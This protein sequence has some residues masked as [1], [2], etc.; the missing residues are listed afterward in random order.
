MAKFCGNC[1]A[2]MDD[3]AAV[4]GY[5]GVRLENGQVG[6]VKNFKV[7]NPEKKKKIK[8]YVTIGA[9]VVA[10]IIVI[11]I[12]GSIISNFTG[13]KGCLRKTMKAFEKSDTTAFTKIATG[14][15]DELD[16]DDA[17]YYIENA[18]EYYANY[19]K[20]EFEDRVGHNYK[21]DYKVDEYFELEGRKFDDF[22]D[23][24]EDCSH[25]DIDVSID[26]IE[27]AEV[28]VIAK[29]GKKSR[30]IQIQ[31]VMSKENGSWRLLGIYSQNS[32]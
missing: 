17:D 32:F 7:D 20:D 31:V 21:L 27:I 11:S 15:I 6:V 28:T 22:I 23:Y 18:I 26:K 1:G 9:S 16:E 2:Q 5:C 10:V 4:C 12:L 30:D 13:Y 8:K 24:L 19:V 29:K 14:I 25:E 3:N